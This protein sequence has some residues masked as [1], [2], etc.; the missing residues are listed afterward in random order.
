MFIDHVTKIRIDTVE[1]DVVVYLFVGNFTRIC[2]INT[3]WRVCIYNKLKSTIYTTLSWYCWIS[4]M[5]ISIIKY[6]TNYVVFNYP[7]LIFSYSI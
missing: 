4:F 5:Y 1:L 7:L 2:L 3:V 6:S